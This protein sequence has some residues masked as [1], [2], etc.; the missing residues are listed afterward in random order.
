M[1]TYTKMKKS[2]QS[3]A[4]AD[5]MEVT[6]H[7]PADLLA[8]LDDWIEAQVDKPSRSEALLRILLDQVKP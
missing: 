1:M 7:I 5:T 3:H 4:T 6:V 8:H 2:P